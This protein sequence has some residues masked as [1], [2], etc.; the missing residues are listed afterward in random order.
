[1]DFEHLVFPSIMRIDWV[2]VYQHPDKIN[3]GCDTPEKPTSAYINTCV[4]Y[5]LPCFLCAPLLMP[6]F[7]VY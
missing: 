4:V 5:P 3:I 1:V 7:Q 2:R 6:Y